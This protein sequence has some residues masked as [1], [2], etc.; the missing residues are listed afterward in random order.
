[1]FD[2]D[3]RLRNF[4][5]KLTSPLAPIGLILKG[6]LHVFVLAGHIFS[7]HPVSRVGL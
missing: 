6:L 7:K 2:S 4:G 5:P 3:L 1:L